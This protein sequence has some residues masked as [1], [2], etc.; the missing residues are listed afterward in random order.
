MTEG[1]IKLKSKIMGHI[2]FSAKQ[3]CY[4]TLWSYGEICVGSNCCGRFGK[5]LKMW[6]ARLKYHKWLMKS[7]KTFSQWADD[8]KTIELQKRN[9]KS[10][11]LYNQRAIKHIKER[12][13]YFKSKPK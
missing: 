11:I 9:I 6:K 1:I 4:A 12:I 8:P 3:N 2:C 7:D 13:E 10:N 5:G